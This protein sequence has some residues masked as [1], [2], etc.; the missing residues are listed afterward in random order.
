MT[1]K[2][3]LR[4]VVIQNIIPKRNDA[5]KLILWKNYIRH[6]HAKNMM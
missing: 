2:K 3:K 5:K 4:S 6:C 1:E